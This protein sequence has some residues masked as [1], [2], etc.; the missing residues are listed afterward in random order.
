MSR[1]AIDGG[2]PVRTEPF[3]AWPVFGAEEERALIEVLRSGKWGALDGSKVKQFQERFAAF[4]DAKHG[5]CVVN[6]TLALEVALRAAGVGPGDEVIVPSYTFIATA[7]SVLAVG[8]RPVFADVDPQTMQIDPASVEER[9]NSRT[10]AVIPV[11]LAGHP[12]DLDAIMAIARRYGLT[13]IEDAAQAHGAAW[14]GRRVG[15]IGHLGTFSFQS[16]KN[17]TAGEGGIVVTNDDALA[18]CVWSIHN[19]GRVPGGLWYQHESIG[20]N[21]RMAEFQAAVLLCQLDRAEEQLHRRQVNAAA[22]SGL[23]AHIDGVEPLTVD[24]RVTSHAWHIYLF[25]YDSTAFGGMDKSTFIRCLQAEGIPAAPGYIPLHRNRAMRQALWEQFGVREEDIPPCPSA[26]RACDE[27]VV[28]LPQSALMGTSQDL[29]S[30]AQA[31]E[32]IQ[33]VVN[34]RRQAK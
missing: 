3:P 14:K 2:D 8:A 12:A 17:I 27:T 15:A 22:L 25:R 34:Q 4:Q 33:A 7:T 30:I 20:W 5:I 11:H 32:K 28:W 23:L 6:G 19:V 13:V 31:L 9:V 21:L 29:A 10:R 1:L 18:A 26:E 16:S 24:S